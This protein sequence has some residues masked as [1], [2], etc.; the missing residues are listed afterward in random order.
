ME[1][2]SGPRALK[3][4]FVVGRSPWARDGSCP[5][6]GA[7][8]AG[9]FSQ[10]TIGLRLRDA[11]LRVALA[12]WRRLVRG[13]RGRRE[14]RFGHAGKGATPSW[15]R[16]SRSFPVNGSR[17]SLGGT[18]PAW[19]R[20]RIEAGERHWGFRAAGE[21]S[22]D[23]LP[24]PVSQSGGSAEVAQLVRAN[25][26]YPLGRRFKSFLRYH[27]LQTAVDRMASRNSRAKIAISSS[28]PTLT[29]RQVGLPSTSPG[30]VMTPRRSIAS[31]TGREG[32]PRSAYTKFA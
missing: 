32:R 8:S 30:R 11:P 12:L 6:R 9:G 18:R 20:Y 23:T 7:S 29:R 5:A 16:A 15:C 13:L 22:L 24:R 1:A 4:D 14:V 21:R 31:N 17:R 28:V 10:A 2:T 27:P 3:V 25:G 19:S 26:S